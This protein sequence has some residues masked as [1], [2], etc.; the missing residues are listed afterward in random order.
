MA[1]EVGQYLAMGIGVGFA[2][3]MKA[4]GFDMQNALD[5][6]LLT[7]DGIL[8]TASGSF[9]AEFD[10]QRLADMIG[11]DIYLDGRLVGRAISG[12]NGVVGI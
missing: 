6:A 2:Q 12:N 3:G 11:Q 8:A 4:V 7:T 10:Y 9:M 1:D 5:S